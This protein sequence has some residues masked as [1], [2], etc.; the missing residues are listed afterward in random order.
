[1]GE[2]STAVSRFTVGIDLGDKHAHVCVLNEEG[3]ILEESR[4]MMKIEALKLRF[5]SMAPARIAME[6]GTHSGWV[7]RLIRELG[8]EV[9][10]ANARKLRL[11]YENDG[12]NDKVDAQYLA[13]LARVDPKLLSPIEHRSRQAQ[14]DLAVLRA[15]DTL[16]QA[17]T[18]LI[19]HVR[20]A[21]KAL[22]GRIPGMSADAFGRKAGGSLPEGLKR[23]LEPVLEMIR[24]LTE[25][26]RVESAR[27]EAV[28]KERYPQTAALQQVDGVGPVTSLAYVLTLGDPA[29]FS[30]SRQVGAYLGLRPKQ[31]QSGESDPELR[32][33]K[34]GDGFLRRLLVGSAQYI[35]GPFG[36]DTDLRRWGL[37]LAGEGKTSKKRAV[38]A[39][40]R[41][42]S[43]LLHRLWVTNQPYEPIKKVTKN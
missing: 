29:R 43:V 17:R 20:G 11:I 34:A 41:K 22:G 23:A 14:E 16:V 2:C 30:K 21:V 9:L 26:I 31:S 4:V 28:A 42:L 25:Q 37:K 8:H 40:A 5:G 13:R 32:I 19:N 6:V 3:E 27:A 38:V 39:V 10:V 12:K 35:L 15:R 1:M 33:T 18:K 24:K 7:S 36:P